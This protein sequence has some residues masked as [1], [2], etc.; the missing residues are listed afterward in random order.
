M[1]VSAQGFT[2]LELLIVV[3]IIAVMSGAI[4]PAFSQYIDNQG[5][6]QAQE[7]VKSDL[8]TTQ[9]RALTGSAADQFIG[10]DPV[11]FWG[12]AF[13]NDSPTYSYFISTGNAT[14]DCSEEVK[15]S[16]TLPENFVFKHGGCVFFSME[17]GDY[18]GISI[19]SSNRVIVGLSGSNTNCKSVVL[20]PAGLIQNYTTNSNCN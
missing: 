2:L 17:D 10:T 18:N 9:N 7:Q 19:G 12:L 20:N 15:G 5:S 6:R 11:L 4:L 1:K 14:D 8:R 3:S 16:Y 13:T